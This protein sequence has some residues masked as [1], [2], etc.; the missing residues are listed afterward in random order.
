MSIPSTVGV[1]GGGRMGA[2]IAHA[3]LQSGAAVVVI[4]SD[5][6]AAGRAAQSIEASINK[7]GE[8]GKLDGEAAEILA[9]LTV[10]MRPRR[11]RP[12]AG[13]S[14][15]PCRRSPSSSA[16]VLAVAE[17]AVARR[18]ARDEHLQPLAC[19]P[20]HR[21]RSPRPPCRAALLQSRA[22]ESARRDRRRT[23]DGPGADDSGSGLGG[24][25]RQDRDHGQGLPR[26]RVF[27]TRCR[28]RSRGDADARGRRRVCRRHR[29]RDDAWATGIP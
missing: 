17:Q 19:R 1:Y 22:G 5:T 14:S 24:R 20:R 13:W 29:R 21:D 12:R 26:L 28:A 9:G 23:A 16:K 11:P 27:A 10:S 6:D 18:V 2:G 15:K 3:F 7:A 4:E 8:L 25:S